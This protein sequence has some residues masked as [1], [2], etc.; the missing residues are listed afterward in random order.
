[1]ARHEA[2]L[3][4]LSTDKAFHLLGWRPVWS[5]GE[6]V[7]ETA[8]WYCKVKGGIDAIEFTESQIEKFE[9]VAMG[10]GISWACL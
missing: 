8:E 7:R 3:L 5:F 4:S 2:S 10:K 1:M 6:T 9:S